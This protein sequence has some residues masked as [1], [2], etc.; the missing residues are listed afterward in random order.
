MSGK[1]VLLE[2]PPVVTLSEVE[3][4]IAC[5]KKQALACLSPGARDLSLM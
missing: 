4:L 2:K 3:E 5:A 1:H